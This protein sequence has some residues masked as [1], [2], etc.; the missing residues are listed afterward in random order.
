MPL[1]TDTTSTTAMS[2]LAVLFAAIDYHQASQASPSPTSFAPPKRAL[3]P[4][5]RGADVD[6]KWIDNGNLPIKKRKLN[7][8]SWERSNF[9]KNKKVATD[10]LALPASLSYSVPSSPN[11][12]HTAIVSVSSSDGPDHDDSSSI[13]SSLTAPEDLATLDVDSTRNASVEAATYEQT[14]PTLPIISF[15]QDQLAAL[16]EQQ[17]QR[18]YVSIQKTEHSRALLHD[19]RRTS[20]FES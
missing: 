19:M 17:Q 8:R 18:L 4:T 15:D 7:R 13:E 10:D 14:M 2:G 1:T 5:K 16:L 6:V 20:S 3:N 11:S 12:V 9:K